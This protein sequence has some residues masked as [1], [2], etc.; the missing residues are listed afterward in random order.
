[1]LSI[2]GR[3]KKQTYI[4]NEDLI[5]KLNII[6]EKYYRGNFV[7][8]LEAVSLSA[9]NTFAMPLKIRWE[10]FPLRPMNLIRK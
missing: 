1:M 3:V 9:I 6:A 8:A 5:N 7:A 10:M 2:K 4:Q